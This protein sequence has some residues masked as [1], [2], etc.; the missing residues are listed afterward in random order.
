M[1][2]DLFII[3]TNDRLELPLFVADSVKELAEKADIPEGNIRSSLSKG[4]RVKNRQGK[5][6]KLF[7][8]KVSIQRK[9]YEY[10]DQ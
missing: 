4:Y 5:K 2:I 10:D 7:R 6:Y 9:D 1:N 8:I 3:A